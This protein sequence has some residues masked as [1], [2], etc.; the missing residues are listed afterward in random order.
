[1]VTE[2]V[3]DVFY[4]NKDLSNIIEVTLNP[5]SLKLFILKNFRK[6]DIVIDMEEYLNISSIIAF[7]L[8]KKRVGYNHGIRSLLYD[9]TVLYNDNQHVSQTFMDLLKPLGVKK[10]VN[11]LL[12]LNYSSKDRKNVDSLL[13]KSSISNKDFVVGFGIGLAESVKERMWPEER[14]AQ[15]ADYLI[16]NKKAKVIFIGSESESEIVGK[17]QSFM[18]ETLN[19]QGYDLKSQSS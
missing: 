18:K 2:R 4:K 13:K 6:Y 15:V 3:K 8:G 9:K 12:S 10:K 16:K 19:I 14:Y 17:I 7:F 11:E 5:L 1:L